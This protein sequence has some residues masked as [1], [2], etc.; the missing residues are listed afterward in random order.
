M[1]MQEHVG[2]HPAKRLRLKV[3]GITLANHRHIVATKTQ[4]EAAAKLETSL[5]HFRQY[6]AQTGNAQE[7]TLALGKPGT[8]FHRDINDH[9][10]PY[11]EGLYEHKPKPHDGA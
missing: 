4:S 7:L 8:P 10:G 1:M 6:A 2:R 5:H 11:L 3:W 9:H